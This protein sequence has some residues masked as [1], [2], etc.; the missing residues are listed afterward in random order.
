MGDSAGAGYRLR[1]MPRPALG[2]NLVCNNGKISVLYPAISGRCQFLDKRSE[3]KN[4]CAAGEY[5]GCCKPVPV[6][7][8]GKALENFGYFV[9]LIAQNIVGLVHEQSLF[10]F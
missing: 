10:Y 2:G 8:R 9:F 6:G 7:S 3:Q 5:G 1:V 4:H